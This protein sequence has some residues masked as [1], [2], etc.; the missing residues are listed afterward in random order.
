[1]TFI[2]NIDRANISVSTTTI[3]GDLHLTPVHMGM[4]TSAFSLAYAAMQI[5]GALWIR[6]YGTRLAVAFAVLFWSLL[7]LGTGMATGFLSLIIARIFF[8]FGEAPI[9]PATNQYNLHWFP[10]KERAFANAIPNAGSWFGL[11]VAPPDPG[12]GLA[13]A[14]LAVG[15]LPVRRFWNDQRRPLVLAY[16]KHSGRAP[17]GKCG[18]VSVH[19]E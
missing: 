13:V 1:M 3:L 4:I 16:S 15:V 6:K 9:F 18:G 19:Q 17:A 7:T 12:V 8:G 2:C 10:V 11:I 5:P 14:R